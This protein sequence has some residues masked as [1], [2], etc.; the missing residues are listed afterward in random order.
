MRGGA[1]MPELTLQQGMWVIIILLVLI[2][3]Q[4]AVLRKRGI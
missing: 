3:A 4:L 2:N 1:N